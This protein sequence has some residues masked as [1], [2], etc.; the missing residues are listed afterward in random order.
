[1]RERITTLDTLTHAIG[2]HSV[3]VALLDAERERALFTARGLNADIG[4][5]RDR[6]V[7]RALSQGQP[8]NPEVD[9]LLRLID[10]EREIDADRAADLAYAVLALRDRPS[11]DHAQ[12]LLLRL[13]ERRAALVHAIAA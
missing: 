4:I 13:G 10:A 6:E 12:A 2:E 5:E 1:L 11:R 3:P 8:L 9:N 7:A